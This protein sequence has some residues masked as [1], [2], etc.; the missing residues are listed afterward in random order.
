[1]VKFS[2]KSLTF[3]T[4]CHIGWSVNKL[5]TNQWH[6]SVLGLCCFLEF[7]LPLFLQLPVLDHLLLFLSKFYVGQYLTTVCPFQTNWCF[8][9]AQNQY[10]TNKICC[11]AQLKTRHRC[12]AVFAI[13]NLSKVLVEDFGGKQWLNAY[14]L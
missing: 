1:M 12:R 7:Y 4:V 11:H 5:S 10:L 2:T 13:R 3:L 9:R 8:R 14:Q 6:T